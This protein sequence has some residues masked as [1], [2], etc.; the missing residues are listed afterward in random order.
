MNFRNGSDTHGGVQADTASATAAPAGVPS[1]RQVC[2]E[3]QAKVEAFLAEEVDSKLLKS[4]QAQ[5]KEA[6]AV[7][8]VAFDKY[9]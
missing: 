9:K 2:L 5:V 3:L 6:V 8:D 4:V 1:L 7:I